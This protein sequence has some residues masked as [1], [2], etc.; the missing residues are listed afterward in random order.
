MTQHN[1]NAPADRE[2]QIEVLELG[3]AAELT[4]GSG[5]GTSEDKRRIYN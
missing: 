5:G 4:L 3:D 2:G 1:D